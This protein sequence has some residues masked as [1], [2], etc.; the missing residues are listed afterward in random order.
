MP[1]VKHAPQDGLHDSKQRPLEELAATEADSALLPTD[2][3]AQDR[4][5]VLG[6]IRRNDT[7][8][9]AM[10]FDADYGL[11]VWMEEGYWEG[12]RASEDE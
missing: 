5:P 9:T 12:K 2:R 11:E 6:E 7:E 1:I 4:T 8:R 3:V 10:G